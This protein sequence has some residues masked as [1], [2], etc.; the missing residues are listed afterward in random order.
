MLEIDVDVG[1]LAPLGR[2]EALEQQVGAVGIDLGHAE[3]ETDRGIGGRTAALAEDALRAR[4]AHDVID[5]EEIGRVLQLRDQCELVLEIGAHLVGNAVRIAA[6]GAVI[7]QV[8]ERILGVVETR[9]QFVGIFV[10]QL[11]ERKAKARR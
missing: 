9:H 11:I 3:A 2:D 8:G 4:E 1:R 5:G 6:G 10:T 7:S